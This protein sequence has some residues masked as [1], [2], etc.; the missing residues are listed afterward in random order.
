MSHLSGSA[1]G[2]RVAVILSGCGYLDGAEINEAVISLLALNR[3]GAQVQCY[4]PDKPQMHVV[5][6]LTGQ[7]RADESRNVL[8]ES[9]RIARGQVA[10]LSELSHRGFDA[11]FMPGGFGVAKNLSTFAVDGPTGSVD[12]DLARVLKEFRAAGK[13]IGAVCISPAVLVLALGEGEVTIGS[14]TGTAGA[15]ETL[16]GVHHVC[17]VDDIHVDG[18]RRIVTAPA[19]MEDV[20][21][22]TVADG[23]EKAV[24]ATLE[25]ASGK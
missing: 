20:Q 3:A 7:P 9:A 2:P 5:D 16:G 19:F 11:L 13:P 24:G 12:P 18:D 23:I 10:P 1:Q 17:P 25:L 6:H 22:A 14:D 15:I 4:A 8:H 21:L